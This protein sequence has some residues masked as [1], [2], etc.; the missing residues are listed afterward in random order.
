MLTKLEKFT[1][2]VLDTLKLIF[3]IIKAIVDN[4]KKLILKEKILFHLFNQEYI[5][6]ESLSLL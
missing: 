4:K 3:M 2:I 1:N 5:L 6:F